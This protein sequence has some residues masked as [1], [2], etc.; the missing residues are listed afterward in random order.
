MP[1][2][3]YE[4]DHADPV[5]AS[6]HTQGEAERSRRLTLARPGVD[7]QQPLFDRFFRDLR[8][9][10]SLALRHFGAVPLRRSRVDA[11]RHHFTF[12]GMPATS[13]T[14]RS[15]RTARR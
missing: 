11:L 8:V 9:L 7:D 1:C 13:S 15:A 2:A 6:E 14:T 5:A 10:N 4:L 3:L 12:M